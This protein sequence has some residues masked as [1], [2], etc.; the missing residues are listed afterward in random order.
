[1]SYKAGA[2][3]TIENQAAIEALIV[4]LGIKF[5]DWSFDSEEATMILAGGSVLSLIIAIT[6]LSIARSAMKTVSGATDA[7]SYISG[8]LNLRK[9]ADMFINET[10]VVIKKK[11]K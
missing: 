1:M 4:F 8:H 9:N 3:D 5:G 11:K 7:T 10:R 6:S 2:K